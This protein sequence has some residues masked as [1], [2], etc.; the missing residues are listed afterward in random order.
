[1]CEFVYVCAV[2]DREQGKDK[3]GKRRSNKADNCHCV[4]VSV[5]WYIRGAV[6]DR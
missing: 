2:K 6:I 4:H 1:M 3:R 5:N